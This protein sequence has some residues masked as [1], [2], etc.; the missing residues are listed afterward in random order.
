MSNFKWVSK[1]PDFSRTPTIVKPKSN[2]RAND[3]P[4]LLSKLVSKR[5]RTAQIMVASSPRY[6]YH[7]AQSLKT[8][9]LG[10]ELARERRF[11]FAVR[12]NRVFGRYLG[13]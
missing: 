3:Y 6:A 12:G 7:V 4:A 5:G 13:R 8:G 2:G 1:V 9:E 11:E 10:G